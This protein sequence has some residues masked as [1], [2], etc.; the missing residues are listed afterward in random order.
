[1]GSTIQSIMKAPDL[2]RWAMSVQHCIVRQ[3][4]PRPRGPQDS[5]ATPAD[6]QQHVRTRSLYTIFNY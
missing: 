5:E 2:K 4:A 6:I 1:M 3:K